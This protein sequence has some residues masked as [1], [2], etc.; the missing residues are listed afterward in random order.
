MRVELAHSLPGRVRLR[1]PELRGRPGA[2]AAVRD[3]L[4]RAPGAHS[5]IV[6]PAS[7]GLLVRFDPRRL[8]VR[9]LIQILTPPERSA[10][11]EI[12]AAAE[13]MDHPGRRGLSQ[14]EA[15]QLR[16]QFGPNLLP[17]APASPLWRRLLDQFTDLSSIVLI[18]GAA[19]SALSGRTWEV[20]AV[21]AAAGLNALIGAWRAGQ[22]DEALS[23]L[24]ALTPPHATVVRGGRL[25]EIP[26]ADLVPGDLLVLQAGDKVPADAVVQ[27][28]ADLEVDERPLLAADAV[29]PHRVE[30]DRMLRAG[31]LVLRG[32]AEAL[33]VATGAQSSLG[34]IAQTLGRA[35]RLPSPTQ[36]R[37]ARIARDLLKGAAVVLGLVT[38]VGLLRGVPPLELFSSAV[39]LAAASIP[40]GLPTYLTLALAAGARRLSRR[41]AYVRDLAVAESVGQI[42]VICTDKTGTLTRG[43]M[44][45][46]AVYTGGE[47]W[48]VTGKGFD[49]VGRFLKG[50]VPAAPLANPDLHRFLEVAV[51]CNHASLVETPEG[52][53]EVHGSQ[54][55]GALLVMALKAGLPKDVGHEP[56]L[57]EE[58]FDPT[59]RRM[60]LTV[61]LEGAPFT[62]SKGAPEAILPLC[63]RILADGQ[64]RGLTEADQAAIREAVHLVTKSGM[65]VLALAYSHEERAPNG[66]IFAGL[67]GIVDPP[68]RDLRS[69]IFR[70]RKRG[71]RTVMLTGD[72]HETAVAVA[73][74][75]GMFQQGD[76]VL[77]GPELTQMSGEELHRVIDR[78]TVFA[79]VTPEQKAQVIR[80]MQRCGHTTAYIG[81]GIDDAP[82][83]RM[84]DIGV[85]PRGRAA[86]VTR[87]AAS[88]ILADDRFETLITAMRQGRNTALNTDEVSRL[89]LVGNTAELVLLAASAIFGL[90][91]ALL[92]LQLLWRNLIGDG[93]AALAVG[94]RHNPEQEDED[95]L[96][97]PTESTRREIVIRGLQMGAAAFGLYSGAIAQG[98]TLAVARTMALCALGAAQ[99]FSLFRCRTRLGTP[100]GLR[101]PTEPRVALAIIS[102]ALLLIA[103]IYFPP[104]AGA[105]GTAP[106]SMGQWLAVLGASFAGN[107]SAVS[108]FSLRRQSP[109]MALA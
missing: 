88:I 27:E 20:A 6:N 107:L 36:R 108:G 105:L 98:A 80:A 106:L 62:C 10:I 14:A 55:E 74:R 71:V 54:T 2:L 60:T 89:L 3:L 22:E 43:E 16:R 91:L 81:D 67:A 28:S 17:A 99:I 56:L 35:E 92:P 39:S 15:V 93:P 49:P 47:W 53:V 84:A 50:G 34:R 38:G 42:D 103:T 30:R 24:R 109:P 82:A 85:V 58:S 63:T 66:L 9:Q 4:V 97:P 61:G 104:L 76:R 87:E 12:A 37:T 32:H 18:A 19:L 7:G 73:R 83:V 44:T 102:S 78:V 25:T 21:A 75:L 40:E 59:L 13:A 52:T 31:S 45:V 79:R 69:A 96:R 94:E 64:I 8:S 101:L 68:R 29:G 72:H 41:G 77:T 23:A 26:A 5:V 95:G 100:C 65:R 48:T 86:D 1:V 90:P 57:H 46:S 33:V 11:A 70:L 51:R